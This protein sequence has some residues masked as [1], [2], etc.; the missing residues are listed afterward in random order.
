MPVNI[1]V[2]RTK[3][4]PKTTVT[5]VLN[6]A[7]SKQALLNIASEIEQPGGYEIWM[8]SREA[9]TVLSM[10]DIGRLGEML[11]A[12]PSLRESKIAL[13][14]AM[15]DAK[16]ADVLETITV[17]RAVGAKVFTDFEEAITWLDEGAVVAAVNVK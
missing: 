16:Q 3:D 9:N 17:D 8:D 10:V 14:T 7:V 12:P 11:A 2:I 15:N 1:K 6:F 4:F 13:V 5:E